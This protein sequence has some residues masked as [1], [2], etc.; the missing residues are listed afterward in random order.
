I[1]YRTSLFPGLVLPCLQLLISVPCTPRYPRGPAYGTN[2]DATKLIHA[3]KPGFLEPP[4]LP[5]CAEYGTL[6]S[7]MTARATNYVY[8]IHVLL[9]PFQALISIDIIPHCP[10]LDTFGLCSRFF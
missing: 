4:P 2:F 1:S 10:G 5:Y 6:H 7:T 3:A 8:L 9:E